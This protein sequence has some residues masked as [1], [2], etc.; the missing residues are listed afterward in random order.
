[1]G[2]R[3]LLADDS[4]TIQKLVKMAL[5]GTSYE[6]YS[7]FDGREALNKANEAAPDIV[8]A[9]AIMPDMD[10]Y[11]LCK[12]VKNDPRLKHVPVVL[13]IG[14]FQPFDEDRAKDAGIDERMIK[15]F[16]A[17]RLIETIEN[18]LSNIS[19]V[20]SED[21]PMDATVNMSP[22]ELAAH[23]SHWQHDQTAMTEDIPKIEDIEFD[24][25]VSFD[26]ESA[27]SDLSRAD[28]MMLDDRADENFLEDPT[29]DGP[30][31]MELSTEDLEDIDDSVRDFDSDSVYGQSKPEMR[32]PARE[33]KLFEEDVEELA[34]ED[35]LDDSFADFDMDSDS[36]DVPI[37]ELDTGPLQE[38]SPE[39]SSF[40]EESDTQPVEPPDLAASAQYAND[41]FLEE[42]ALELEPEQDDAITEDLEPSN[43]SWDLVSPAPENLS[44]LTASTSRSWENP[45]ED[46]DLDS[47]VAVSS[48]WS[49][50]DSLSQTSSNEANSDPLADP[51]ELIELEEDST[52]DPIEEL[53]LEESAFDQDSLLEDG[54]FEPLSGAIEEPLAEALLG[55][56]A[57]DT[58]DTESLET[59]PV[60]AFFGESSPTEELVGP[61]TLSDPNDFETQE[62]IVLEEAKDFLES[63]ETEAEHLEDVTFDVVEEPQ[64]IEVANIP[65]IPKILPT[66]DPVNP[67]AATPR[68]KDQELSTFS[69]DLL[70]Q[71]ADKVAERVLEKF[72]R[73]TIREIAWEVIPELSEAIIKKRIF[74]LERAS[75][76]S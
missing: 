24:E 59:E 73:D 10:G 31:T 28:T 62:G 1:M 17:S 37:E 57:E 68:P 16:S 44:H 50:P 67:M 70:N 65:E 66:H 11:D 45:V 15:P 42:E 38:L 32:S 56:E 48:D 34:E 21:E 20:E 40:Y 51:S 39:E 19:G 7:A 23:T 61:H 13:L 36:D 6:L 52:F 4:A 58:H 63:H 64:P 27:T 75:D 22:E 74:E 71:L 54:D 9:D 60:E 41:D 29:A 14:R 43:T 35:L 2:K 49:A 53:P 33:E 69:E 26:E 30:M 3:V 46:D 18:L 25:D 12:A 55:E 72:E 5:S 76:Q 8:L 47:T